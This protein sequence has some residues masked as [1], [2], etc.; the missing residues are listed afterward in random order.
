MPIVQAQVILLSLSPAAM[1]KI[2]IWTPGWDSWQ[3]VEDFLASD[4]NYFAIMHPPTPGGH[5]TKSETVTETSHTLTQ[6]Q[7]GS[8]ESPFTQVIVE[9]K[10]IRH[11]ETGGYYF[12]DFNGDDLDLQKINKAQPPANTKKKSEPLK[13]KLIN[14][15]GSER[16]A[17]PRHNFKIE[18]VIV[19]KSRSFRTYSKNISITGTLL[20]DE[21][22]KDFLNK[23]FDLIVVNPF[24][25]N[26][27]KA[28]LLFKAKIVGDFVDPRRLMFIEQD[29][30]MT[31]KLNALLQAYVVYQNQ[32]H[33][34]PTGSSY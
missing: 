6:T 29:S 8:V 30:E 28:R 33:R 9:N 26:R 4:Q 19:S 3:T 18:V 22:P 12:Q 27:T 5:S 11:Q 34:K 10:P 15:D 25:T 16:R 2:L 32:I 21:V 23:P 13:P 31:I 1:K 14:A 24:E 17:E 20:E 7:T